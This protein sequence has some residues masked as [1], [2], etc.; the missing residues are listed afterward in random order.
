MTDDRLPV[1][2]VILDGLG[3]RGCPELDGQTPSEAAATPI[4]DALAAAWQNGVHIPFG[5]GRATSS[6]M[7]HWSLFGF[8]NVP[9]P[10]RAAIEGFGQ[11]L[12]LPAEVPMFHLALRA[13][14][15]RD[16]AMYLG[17]RARPRID[18]AAAGE[19]FAALGG[20]QV[21]GIEFAIQPLRTGESV[22]LAHGAQSRD[23][24]DT[25]ALFDHLHPWM[26][27]R[28]LKDAADPRAASHVAAS[29][30]EW[31]LSGREILLAHPLNARRR[32]DDMPA[33]DVPVTKWA[34]WIDP[35]MPSFREQVGLAGA[36]VTDSALYRGLACMLGMPLV[37]LSYDA[38][39][40]GA[41]M[42]R[43]LQHAGDL[44]AA[45]ADFV[46]VHIKAT[47]AAGH[48]KQ[49]LRKRD[50]I[51]AIDAGLEG[52]LRLAEH[53]VVAVTGDHA[54]PSRGALLHSG[55]PT[56]FVVAGPGVTADSVNAFGERY[57]L[58]GMCGRLAAND[59]MPLLVGLANRPFFYDHRPGPWRSIALPN[60]PE[61]MPLQIAKE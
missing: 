21:G 35:A 12:T 6:E 45:G 58:Q 2:L 33:L 37:D 25:D 56:P 43:R 28:A 31:L 32:S 8:Q 1:V 19:L 60:D 10:G 27:P 20:R 13:G 47:D 14:H 38:A 61:P 23:V 46:H 40:P 7:A 18:D 54:T 15:L 30:Q 57:A 34:S 41:D 26:R 16:N 17:T 51:A 55:D 4:L 5:P 42:A 29:L 50:V 24:S 3:D 44:V 36:A 53:A 22:L 52:L 9:F 59:I 48:A 11:G 49:P 39:D